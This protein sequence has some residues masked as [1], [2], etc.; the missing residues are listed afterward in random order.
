MANLPKKNPVC[1]KLIAY[2]HGKFQLK[3][4]WRVSKNGAIEFRPY[5]VV[6]HGGFTKD[7]TAVFEWSDHSI[8]KADGDT[9]KDRQKKKRYTR[10]VHQAATYYAKRKKAKKKKTYKEKY[11]KKGSSTIRTHKVKETVDKKKEKKRGWFTNYDGLVTIKCTID[12]HVSQVTID[13]REKPFQPKSISVSRYHGT[14]EEIRVTV[15]SV[16]ASRTRPV[17]WLYVDRKDDRVEAEFSNKVDVTKS[18]GNDDSGGDINGIKNINFYDT[19]EQGHRYQYR[20][21]AQNM[22]PASSN[23]TS[24][25]VG[26][27]FTSP[28]AVSN[29]T[30]ERLRNRGEAEN[31]IRFT[32]SDDAVAKGYYKGFVLEFSN[33]LKSDPIDK[34]TWQAVSYDA[35]K[36]TGDIKFY[37]PLKP[38]TAVG[39]DWMDTKN[40]DDVLL[41]HIKCQK[42]KIYR[43]RIRPYN[44]W[45][46]K[47]G[48]QQFAPEA[49]PSADGTDPTY[50]E[51]Y[52][53]K[54]VVAKFN[55][56]AGT[57]DLSVERL[58]DSTTTDKMFIQVKEDGNWLDVTDPAG[59]DVTPSSDDNRIFTFT[60]TNIPIGT[61]DQL[62][63]RVAFGCSKT[64]ADGTPLEIGNGKTAWVES[65]DVLVIS[66]PNPPTPVMPVNNS[67]ALIDDRTVRLA[68]IHS[69]TDG[70]GQEAAQ[71][72]LVTS[73]TET[74][75]VGAQ[76]YYDLDISAYE[77]G[78][79][80][81][82]RVKTKGKHA[83][84][85]EWSEQYTLM[86][87]ARPRI[88]WTSPGNGSSV[89]NLPLNL[90]WE[91]QDQ[92]GEM[93]SLA[94]LIGQ[95]GYT[96]AQFDLPTSGNTYPLTEYL[97]DDEE[98]Y[99]LTLVAKSTIG[100]DCT[101]SINVDIRYVSIELANGYEPN[102][103]FDEDTG[104]AYV[105]IS[106][107]ATGSDLDNVMA[108]N[109][110]TDEE[111]AETIPDDE[112]AALPSP[113]VVTAD[114]ARVYVY[115]I[116][117]QNRALVYSMVAGSGETLQDSYEFIDLY[118]PVNV[119]FDYEV[120]QV[121]K[122]GQVAISNTTLKFYTLWWY[123]YYD[124]DEIVK[125]R[126]NP[127]GNAQYKR[128][129]KQQIRYSGREYPVTYDS[130]AND[131]TYSLNFS[132]FEAIDDGRDTLEQFKE[133]MRSGAKG[134]WKSFEGDVYAAD[135]DFSYSS[136]YTDGIPS[137]QCSLNVTRGDTEEEL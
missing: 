76:A 45:N 37:D 11:K 120:L 2:D 16:Q 48:T 94:L 60:D 38:N 13:V 67:F 131:E 80:L 125:V 54:S 117:R 123:V 99:Q 42:D 28:P 95:D 3:V 30:H 86:L 12:K 85:S 23:K 24:T 69:P 5:V 135:F 27:F 116:H 112:E 133:M 44:Y 103:L 137:W 66:K 39:W 49:Y 46:G 132:L 51:P 136:D 89:S 34:Q 19:G 126:W 119:D 56:A 63:Y 22:R 107:L 33:S 130:N 81:K 8:N 9:Y 110:A 7:R 25:T 35:K 88:T 97:F 134:V 57:I 10:T 96:L 90:G 127:S 65:N 31:A 98:S 75:S 72:E 21:T 104:L 4:Q 26:W 70:T 17:R 115:R 68:W 64:P 124:E 1:G 55:E 20:I 32:R 108:V 106:R 102:A 61:A 53:P 52:P 109:E 113:T 121:T 77:S 14:D 114:I 29:V 129:E 43:Y 58:Y 71:I 40:N 91:Y 79:E 82:W 93:E 41:R 122:D 59:L 92:A 101:A 84:Y 18:F 47:D 50:N 128:P 36:K 105:T 62:R 78:T 74:V 15:G 100:V 118:A 111:I 73:S 83:S 87:Y 6:T